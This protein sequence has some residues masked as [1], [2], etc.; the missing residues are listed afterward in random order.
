MS[1]TV[2]LQ[3]GVNG[4]RASGGVDE[5]LQAR[6]VVGEARSFVGMSFKPAKFRGEDFLKDDLL[7]EGETGVE[8]ESG[9]DRFKGIGEEG[10]LG[11]S[12]ALFFATAETQV[13][14]DSETLGG[15]DQVFGA[16]EMGLQ[17][18]ELSL[19][20]LGESAE[21]LDAGDESE[22]GVADEFHLFVVRTES[23]VLASVRAMRKRLL[24][25]CSIAEAV[26]Q[27]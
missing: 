3:E 7:R 5:F 27:L 16:D 17:F 4:L 22:D 9:E 14:S 26:A 20:V 13:Q 12:A 2:F 11:S 1:G 6:F 24:D 19:V 10:G 23:L 15:A 21:K 25:E 8:V 18:R